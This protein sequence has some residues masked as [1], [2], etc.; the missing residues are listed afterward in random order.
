MKFEPFALHRLPNSLMFKDKM[1]TFFYKTIT[2]NTQSTFNIV[3]RVGQNVR[4]LITKSRPPKKKLGLVLH[5]KL[6]TR[7]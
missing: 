1:N 2:Q 6:F 4:P 3:D 5:T 7:E